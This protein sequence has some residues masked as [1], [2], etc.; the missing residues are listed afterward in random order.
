M[1]AQ[2]FDGFFFSNLSTH[3]I[4]LPWQLV[5]SLAACHPCSSSGLSHLFSYW[6]HL[7]GLRVWST[8]SDQSWDPSTHPGVLTVWVI[9]SCSHHNDPH[10]NL[11]Y[12]KSQEHLFV[13]RTKTYLL[14]V[15]DWAKLLRSRATKPVWH[16]CFNQ[17]TWATCLLSSYER[18]WWRNH[19]RSQRFLLPYLTWKWR[20]FQRVCCGRV[21]EIVCFAAEV[22]LVKHFY[23]C[24]DKS[25]GLSE[26]VGQLRIDMTSR[27][28]TDCNLGNGETTDAVKS[29][30]K[31]NNKYM[32][33]VIRWTI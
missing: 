17:I 13:K 32:F 5:I 22:N 3:V 24:P 7:I 6:F 25:V 8:A 9:F 27:V 20:T 10:V 1:P 18:L 28:M 23:G 2:I 16:H 31:Q 19:P 26:R 14:R 12:S 30:A 15:H 21:I 11:N 4:S 29:T 33:L